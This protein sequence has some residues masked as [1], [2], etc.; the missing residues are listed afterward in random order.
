MISHIRN[1]SHTSFCQRVLDIV[2]QGRSLLGTSDSPSHFYSGAYIRNA[3]GKEGDAG[4]VAIVSIVG[5]SAYAY[6]FENCSKQI[7]QWSS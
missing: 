4:T 6:A 1:A 7:L 2:V 3:Y 5:Y